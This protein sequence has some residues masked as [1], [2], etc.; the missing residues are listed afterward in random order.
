VLQAINR[1]GRSN[2]ERLIMAWED[3]RDARPRESEAIAI[4]NDVEKSVPRGSLEAL[5]NYDIKAI[6]WTERDKHVEE[7]AA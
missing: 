5:A 1:P 2:V 4:L 7:L 6:P 3:T